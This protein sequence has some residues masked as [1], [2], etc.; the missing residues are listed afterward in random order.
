MAFPIL[1][2]G[3]RGE[4]AKCSLA[5]DGIVVAVVVPK[6]RRIRSIGERIIGIRAAWM[7]VAVSIVRIRIPRVP[8]IWIVPGTTNPL[9]PTVVVITAVALRN[10]RVRTHQRE[11][12]NSEQQAEDQKPKLR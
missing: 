2:T 7:V 8:I 3:K 9:T 12:S 10:H 6:V 5:V 1:S 4:R 11:R